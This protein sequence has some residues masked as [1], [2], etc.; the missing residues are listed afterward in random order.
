MSVRAIQ[1]RVLCDR[2]TLAELWRTHQV[3]NERLP[4]LLSVLLRMRRGECGDTPAER[5]LYQVI[6]QFVLA[7]NAKDAPYLLNSISIKDWKPATATKQNVKV[8]NRNGDEIEIKGAVWAKE[9]AK[10]SAAGKLLYDKQALVGDLPDTLR[11]MIAR[12]VVAIISGHDELVRLWKQ[13][14]DD[15]LQRKAKWE[16][17]ADHQRY[18]T[19][20]PRFEQFEKEAGGPATKRR[21]R[22]HK[23]LQWLRD[24]PDLAAWRGAEARVHALSPAATQRIAKARPWKRSRVEAEEFWKA[25]PE[26]KELDRL[27]GYY[28][29][30]FVRRRRNRNNRW[31]HGFKQRPTFTLPDAVK[32]PRWF[33][34]NAPQ[35]SPQGYRRLVLP[36]SEGDIGSLELLLLKGEKHQGEYPRGW[37]LVRFKGDPRLADFRPC[38]VA[39]VFHK[40][41]NKGEA[42]EKEA[43]EF[44]DRQINAVRPAQI[45]GVKL[46]FKRVRLNDD[47]G[48]RSAVPYLVFT[49]NTEDVPA[50][51]A[52]KRIKWVEGEAIA[53]SGRRRK[54]I[55]VPD[56]LVACAVDF[57]VRNLGFAT[58]AEYRDGQPRV[59]RS[60]NIWLAHEEKEGAHPGRWSLGPDLA[61]LARHKRHIRRLRQMRGRPVLG[62]KS[63]VELQDHITHMAEDR[64]KKG[65]RAIINF[66]LNAAGEKNK[67]GV[68]FPRAD[69]LVI[70]SLGGLLPDAERERG[71]NRALIEFNRGHLVD[72]I[73]EMAQDVGLRVLT[74]SPVGTSQVCSR[75]GALG[76]RYS[77]R[78][79]PDTRLPD[80]HFGPVEKLFACRCGYHSNSDHNASV[81]LHRRLCMGDK[82]VAAFNEF[83]E[84]RDIERRQI[85]E[86]LEGELLPQ[87]RRLHGLQAAALDAEIPF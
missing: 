50:T 74:V 71:I 64:F 82:A 5:K 37:V 76:R 54:T 83:R 29:R 69:V 72:R 62:E 23:Y 81:N 43:F 45:S 16:S 79:S 1:A 19:L 13:E 67:S 39:D 75:C 53:K 9:A 77:I 27:H 68:S 22:W 61:H 70:E 55:T 38:K 60:R 4:A 14:H 33:V 11:Q 51:E 28:E 36:R 34:F 58:L 41:K 65:A 18:L 80:I 31:V 57:G 25:N 32:H 66:A 87:L 7:R 73:R 44:R 10:L 52:A 35:T 63:H 21:E 85:L 84:K 17:E 48:L 3:F 12:E 86:V 30:E 40:G 49:C 26:L 78:R 42:K 59:L 56:G 20:R 6:A 15:W 47:G 8:R 24:N 2:E 46:M